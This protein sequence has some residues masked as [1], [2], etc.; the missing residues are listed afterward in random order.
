[1]FY[2]HIAAT[3]DDRHYKTL[4]D[5]G[6]RTRVYID[7]VK[8]ACEKFD[9]IVNKNRDRF[10][11]PL[12]N[13]NMV[14]G[15][16]LVK[17]ESRL[18]Y[19]GWIISPREKNEL[20]TSKDAAWVIDVDFEK[21][22]ICTCPNEFAKAERASLNAPLLIRVA[23]EYNAKAVL[24]LHEQLPSPPSCTTLEYAPPGTFR[25]NNR[26]HIYRC[27]NIQHHGFIQCLEYNNV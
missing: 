20:F 18:G 8:M 6:I 22:E 26:K 21:G 19:K 17:I 16:V 24:H 12:K 4:I 9:E 14:F 1:M 23:Q 7:S 5:D 2:S 27:F 15:S 25:D 3:I 11:K 13:G 10:F